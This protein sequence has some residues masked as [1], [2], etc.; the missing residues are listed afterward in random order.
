[1]VL[2]E[3]LTSQARFRR[4]STYVANL[5][6]ELSREKERR[7]NQFG[8]PVLVRCGK[9][10]KFD[11]VCRTFDELNLSSTHSAPSE[12]D[13]APVSL[14]SRTNSVRFKFSTWKVRRL[15]QAFVGSRDQFNLVGF[16]CTKNINNNLCHLC[17]M[18]MWDLKTNLAVGCE[19]PVAL[20]I[21]AR[22]F[23]APHLGCA[24][25]LGL[26]V[27]VPEYNT[28]WALMRTHLFL[29]TG[30]RIRARFQCPS[31]RSIPLYSGTKVGTGSLCARVFRWFRG[32]LPTINF[33]A[34]FAK[35][36]SADGP[37]W[38]KDNL[39]TQSLDKAPFCTVPGN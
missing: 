33:F 13:V 16:N 5:T 32:V 36:A 28:R 20:F 23:K 26:R 4:R 29:S 17:E 27:L 25:K 37:K 21:A 35:M 15:N 38:T 10:V 34:L 30:A 39:G 7:L 18:S 24:F 3:Q 12:S 14:Q 22:V 8:T 19:L 2:H 11:R 31:T 6:C 1:M 9:S